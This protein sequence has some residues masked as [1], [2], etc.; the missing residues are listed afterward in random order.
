MNKPTILPFYYPT[1]VMCIDDAEDALRAVSGILLAD[2]LNVESYFE[3]GAALSHLNRKELLP[4][5]N[6]L[7]RRDDEEYENEWLQSIQFQKIH[8]QLFDNNRHKQISVVIVDYDMPQMNGLE[9]CKKI[10]NPYTRKI[11]LTGVADEKIGID[12]LN[13]GVIHQYLR[14][15]DS[16]LPQKIRAAVKLAQQQYFQHIGAQISYTYQNDPE[17]LLFYDKG[18]EY[19]AAVAQRATEYYM[20]CA[21][22]SYIFFDEIGCKKSGF[23]VK[24]IK[25]LEADV[26]LTEDI[27]SPALLKDLREK[28]KLLRNPPNYSFRALSQKDL[29]NIAFPAKPVPNLPKFFVAENIDP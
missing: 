17:C 21:S 29:D 10:T 23:I 1:T 25:R 22:G 8:H 6:W 18:V 15:Q 20:W 14:K 2:D 13:C 3:L 12:A 9:F 7:V 5:Q 19:L 4:T 24:S 26:E 27:A 28:R 11:L 16:G